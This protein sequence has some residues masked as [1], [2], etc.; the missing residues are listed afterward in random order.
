MREQRFDWP[1]CYEAEELVLNQI[2]AFCA[3]NS[4]AAQMSERMRSETGT[5]LIDGTDHLV[6]PARAEATLRKAGYIRDPLGDTP[7]SSQTGLWHPDA[8]LPRVILDATVPANGFP[9]SL[10]IRVE[11]ISDF[12]AA[13]HLAAEPEGEPFTRF[14]RI[15]ISL[16]NGTRFEAIERSGYRGYSV[17]ASATGRVEA[18]REA[19]RLW[20]T[21]RRTFDDDAEGFKQ[22]H[23]F[24]D[25]V[26]GLMGRDLAYHIMFTEER[27]Y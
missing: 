6:L 17:E 3:H 23:M 1:L 19:Q 15:P 12:I 20:K 27:A 22:A 21:R 25:R 16:E 14:R 18:W 5:L 10:A 4:A 24:L 7:V 11:S 8:M 2:E 9:S 26:I 13:H